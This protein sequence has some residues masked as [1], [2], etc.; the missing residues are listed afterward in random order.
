MR[1][2]PRLLTVV[3]A[4]LVGALAFALIQQVRNR[5]SDDFSN[6]RSDQLVELLRSLDAANQRLDQQIADLTA[7][8]EE[9][10]NSTKRTKAATDAAQAQADAFAIL[11][12]TAGATGPGVRIEVD[13]PGATVDAGALLDAVEE[14]RNA[15]AEV[16]VING[17]VRVVG[18][19]YIVDDADGI[20]I[21]GRVVQ[22]PYIIEAIG[23]PDNLVEGSRFPGGLVDTLR[24]RGATVSLTRSDSITITALADVKTPEYAR[25]DP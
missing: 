7:T 15:G 5:D 21:D 8:R 6:V 4:V 11:A 9:L 22:A 12:G 10:L 20:R 14:L 1:E 23:D 3:V 25:A 19:T 13:D 17:S 2:K 18:R 24:S 16:I